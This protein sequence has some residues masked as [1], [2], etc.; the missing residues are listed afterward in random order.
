MSAIDFDIGDLREPNLEDGQPI[1]ISGS[2][3]LDCSGNQQGVPGYG[4][5]EP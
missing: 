5:K 2:P 3:A 4:F 1:T